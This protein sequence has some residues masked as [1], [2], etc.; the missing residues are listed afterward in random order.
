MSVR[1]YLFVIRLARFF[2]RKTMIYAQGVGPLIRKSTR[3]AV[4]RTL[5]AVNLI[6]VRDPDSK[7][8]LESIGVNRVPIHL[9][10]DPSFWVEPDLDAADRLLAEYMD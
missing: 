7:A 3:R 2:G 8:L 9:S 5:N 4:A 6:T 1:Y 10:A